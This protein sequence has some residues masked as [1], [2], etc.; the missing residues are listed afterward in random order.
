MRGDDQLG[1]LF[2][3]PRVLLYE[4]RDADPFFREHLTERSEHAGAVVDADAEICAR[5]DLAHRDH[6]DAV[7]EAERGPALHAAANGPGEIDE[8]ADDSGRGG[9]SAG[10]LADQ[11]DLAHQVAFDE[12]RIAR[13]FDL[14]QWVLEW[15]HR[16]V[17]PSFD[18]PR[19]PLRV[20]DELDRV[21]ELACISKVDRL[22]AIDA[23]TEDVVWPDLDLV[24]DR[25]E[26]RKLVGGIESPDGEG[27]ILS[28]KAGSLGPAAG[29]AR[30]EPGARH[31]A[32]QE[33]W[34]AVDARR[35]ALD[36]VRLQVGAKGADRRDPASDRRFEVDIDVAFG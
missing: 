4:A 8:V 32:D 27:G 9:P 15:N 3:H 24:S 28:G 18:P 36:A 5:L 31:R 12:H 25:P 10:T 29:L 14:G 6:A 1:S 26:D 11:Q 35:H 13:S 17:D 30:R 33:I 23:F 34:G 21:A 16:R 2:L 22:D 19:M 7:V 20:R